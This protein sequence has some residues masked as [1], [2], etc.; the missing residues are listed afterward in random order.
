MPNYDENYVKTITD[1]A[2]GSFTGT[3]VWII[4]SCILAFIG[5]LFLYIVFV[6]NKEN[7][8]SGNLVKVHKFLNFKLT[9]FEAVLKVMYLVA[10]LSLT[11]SS[12][13]FIGTNF[14]TFIYLLIFWNL[15]LRITFEV[16]LKLFILAKDVSDINKK[17]PQN[18]AEKKAKPKKDEN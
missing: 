12:F 3:Q 11:L 7:K 4:V 2:N 1:V 6:R 13:A 15:F 17:I 18:E 16:L 8:Y 10:A 5:G 9:I 14:F